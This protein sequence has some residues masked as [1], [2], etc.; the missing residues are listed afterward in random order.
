MNDQTKAL[1]ACIIALGY[2]NKLKATDVELWLAIDSLKQAEK[3]AKDAY[4]L[5]TGEH[6]EEGE[7]A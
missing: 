2:L 6:F 1:R 3:F 5:A 7:G 4:F